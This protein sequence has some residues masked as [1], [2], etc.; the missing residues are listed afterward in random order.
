M[1]ADTYEQGRRPRDRMRERTEQ[2]GGRSALAD[3][4]ARDHDSSTMQAVAAG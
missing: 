1:T 3:S 4:F 2:L